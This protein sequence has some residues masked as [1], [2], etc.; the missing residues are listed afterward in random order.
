MMSRV[1][2]NC[3]YEIFK[4]HVWVRP[5]QSMFMGGIPRACSKKGLIQ[6][7]AHGHASKLSPWCKGF[8][9]Q[10][11]LPDMLWNEVHISETSVRGIVLVSK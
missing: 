11:P 10:T 7:I 9:C 4:K 6:A 1:C 2:S 8:A 5:S 3:L